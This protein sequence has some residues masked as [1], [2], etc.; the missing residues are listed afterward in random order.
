[1]GHGATYVT[2][3]YAHLKPDTL[4]EAVAKLSKAASEGEV[5][6]NLAHAPIL[7]AVGVK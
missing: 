1:L 3:R 6:T 7:K 2:E 5:G 4:R